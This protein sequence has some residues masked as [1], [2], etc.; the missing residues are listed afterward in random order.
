MSWK[1][2]LDERKQKEEARR[3]FRENNTEFFSVETWLKLILAGIV[4]TLGFGI[5]YSL[6]VRV[7]HVTFSYILALM[8]VAIAKVLKKIA[9]TGNMKIAILT[10]IFYAA[11]IFMSHVFYYALEYFTLIDYGTIFDYLFEPIVW[12]TALSALSDS[13]IMPRIISIIGGF[14]AYNSA[15]YD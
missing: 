13:G 5:L 3:Y 11:S 14:Y 8:G 10:I 4:L 1:E 9:K 12:R 15:L 7:T 6:F 2:D